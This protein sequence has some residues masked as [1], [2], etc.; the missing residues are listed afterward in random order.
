[1]IN[2][3]LNN[4]PSCKTVLTSTV[5]NKVWNLEN[6]P[7]IKIETDNINSDYIDI[8]VIQEDNILF[9]DYVKVN[10]G[11]VS[12]KFY[13]DEVLKKTNN[14][15]VIIGDHEEIFNIT[16]RKIYGT[17]KY[18]N[19]KPVDTPIINCS[20]SD[21]LCL[22]DENGK[23]ELFLNGKEESIGVFDRNYSTETLE[24]WLYNVNLKNDIELDIKLDKCE[25]YGIESWNQECSTYI[26][27]IPMSIARIN[28][29]SKNTSRNELDLIMNKDIWPILEKDDVELFFNNEQIEV[30]SFV[31]VDDFLL[32]K[33][34][35]NI[36]RKG[37]IV[38]IPKVNKNG[39]IK[40][41]IKDRYLIE[42][43]IQISIGE[44]YY[45]IN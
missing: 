41:V 19:G 5:K 10:N 40:I 22:G 12:V 2:L 26:H 23:F 29:I 1:M 11:L 34:N 21:I 3:I 31:K 32:K 6:K 7:Y 45:F 28:E 24:A 4:N 8:K 37:Y 38:S 43:N 25:L 35:Q 36:F 33:D 44:G 9:S 16:T 18:L 42:N 15:K 30:L 27:F 17:V 39:V 14:I 20:N 13:L